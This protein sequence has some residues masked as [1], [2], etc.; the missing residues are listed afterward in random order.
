MKKRNRRIS[1]GVIRAS[2]TVP[3]IE[4][5]GNSEGA[6]KGWEDRSTK[7]LGVFST[8]KKARDWLES[9]G[10]KDAWIHT[11]DKYTHHVKQ[12]DAN[13]SGCNKATDTSTDDQPATVYAS[14]A[15]VVHCKSSGTPI[16]AKKVWEVDKPIDFMWMPGG[17][18]TI[19]ASYGRS[20]MD[21][22]PIA[23]TV[24]CTED[25]ASSVQTAFEAV[26]AANPRRPPYICIEHQAKERAGEPVAFEWRVDPEP[27]IYCRCLPS[28]LGVKNVNGKIHT[29]FSPTFGT[30]ADY[31]KMN[32]TDCDKTPSVCACGTGAGWYFPDGV[33]GSLQ[34]PAKVVAPDVQS[35]GSLTNWNAFKEILPI[36]ARETGE[37]VEA[38]GNSEGAKKGAET[39]RQHGVF[40]KGGAI[41][42]HRDTD[43]PQHGK[44]ISVHDSE[45]EAEAKVQLRNAG[46]TPGEK[47][48]YKIKYHVKP[49]SGQME[50][51]SPASTDDQPAT[52]HATKTETEK[53]TLTLDEAIA[54]SVQPMDL[55]AAIRASAKILPRT[56]EQTPRSEPTNAESQ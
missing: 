3:V 24:N 29:S 18:H 37:R 22:R 12:Y 20:E 41:G 54:A 34:N 56:G 1:N 32:C 31:G 46:R 16:K 44:L 8:H 9:S 39:K 49:M 50:A 4:A 25:C 48:Y 35:V 2:E 53:K 14:A 10:H 28:E 11:V 30:D 17:I 47:D 5:A 13:I 45:E 21:L 27:A 33:R 36:A 6:K 51:S 43:H 42:E 7:I 38:A 26:R 15:G 40:M 23:L 52:V 55:D 19:H